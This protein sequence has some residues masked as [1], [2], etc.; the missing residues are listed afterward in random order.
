MVI[1]DD[2]S[3]TG[4]FFGDNF[5][6]NLP[7]MIRGTGGGRISLENTGFEVKDGASNSFPNTSG[8]DYNYIA[9]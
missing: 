9:F 1:I 3:N 8:E 7:I 5:S 2:G 4:F 6:S